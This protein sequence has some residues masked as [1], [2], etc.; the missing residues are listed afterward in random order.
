[1]IDGGFANRELAITQS[2]ERNDSSINVYDGT[3]NTASTS[4]QGDDNYTYTAFYG[5]A[6]SNDTSI[7]MTSDARNN[8][9]YAVVVGA[10][11]NMADIDIDASHENY[12]E[13]SQWGNGNEAYV[14]ISNESNLNEV[15]L[16]QASSSSDVSVTLMDSSSNNMVDVYQTWNDSATVTASASSHNNVTIAQ[17]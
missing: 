4:I 5:G 1:M 14:D 6:S 8:Q 3:D 16:E 10:D 15:Y 12:V 2:G 7:D 17:Y 9:V 13:L 11:N